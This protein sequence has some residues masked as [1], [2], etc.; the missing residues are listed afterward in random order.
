ME[1]SKALKLSDL[2]TIEELQQ[3]FR[4][5]ERTLS[6][7]LGSEEAKKEIKS[8]NTFAYQF[9]MNNFHQIEKKDKILVNQT[10]KNVIRYGVLAISTP[11]ILNIS[12]AR[13][14]KNKIFDMH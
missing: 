4:Q 13:L 2:P 1:N 7:Q 9:I 12:L 8:K 5:R 14:T 3:R 10:A 6:F 11:L